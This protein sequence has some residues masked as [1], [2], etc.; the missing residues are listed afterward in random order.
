MRAA[1]IAAAVAALVVLASGCGAASLDPVQKAAA[2]TDQQSAKT[3]MTMHGGKVVPFQEIYTTS[4]GDVIVYLRSPSFAG[5]LPKGKTWADMLRMLKDTSSAKKV[6][7]A[8]I[9]GVETTHYRVDVDL[10]K[11]AADD[12][13]AAT[14]LG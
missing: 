7:S 12:P 2:A 1:G 11:L 6:G 5:Q 4:S 9:G 14:G 10:K 13:R 3:Q 8:Q